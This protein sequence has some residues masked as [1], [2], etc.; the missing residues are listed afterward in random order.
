MVKQ[1]ILRQNEQLLKRLLSVHMLL[2]FLGG[3]FLLLA[4]LIGFWQASRGAANFDAL[5]LLCQSCGFGL[6][7]LSTLPIGFR[8]KLFFGLSFLGLCGFVI[9]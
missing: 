9:I 5:L 4:S 3:C 1:M 7:V 8:S 2:A 6:I